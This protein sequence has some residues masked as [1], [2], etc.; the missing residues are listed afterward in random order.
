MS[1]AESLS[2]IRYSYEDINRHQFH[3]YEFGVPR[4]RFMVHK[5][6]NGVIAASYDGNRFYEWHP[7]DTQYI[8]YNPDHHTAGVTSRYESVLRHVSISTRR[9][10]RANGA[11][12]V[13]FEFC[14]S[15]FDRD[16]KRYKTTNRF[17]VSGTCRFKVWAADD[18]LFAEAVATN[19]PTRIK[20]NDKYRAFNRQLK[21]LRAVLT[22]QFRTG[23]YSEE[24]TYRMY[25]S[26][27]KDTPETLTQ[28]LHQYV[29]DGATTY[30]GHNTVHGHLYTWVQKWIEVR[31]T[32]LLRP[33]VLACLHNHR[34]EAKGVE[35]GIRR[36]KNG[37]AY[38]QKRYL[39]EHCI[40]ISASNNSLSLSDESDDQNS[41]L[42]PP[43]GLREV[44]VSGEAQ[45][46]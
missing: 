23:A 7:D 34:S 19:T 14:Q 26:F 9:Q 8:V 45:V 16:A 22:A 4:G 36:V 31:P 18:R 33:I 20:D 10:K 35:D 44:Q 37:L 5:Q 39:R 40:K 28:A 11:E 38:V 13:S 21:E 1:Y 2:P 17:T 3:R 42:L 32:D 15:Q 43:S 27:G 12:V 24:L 6:P 25:N 41:E 46:C 30:I 29:K